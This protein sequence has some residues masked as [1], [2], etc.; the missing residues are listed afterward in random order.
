MASF[1]HMLQADARHAQHPCG[2]PEDA[3]KALQQSMSAL[4][5]PEICGTRFVTAHLRRTAMARR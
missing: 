5:L 2:Q 4:T 3:A 1:L